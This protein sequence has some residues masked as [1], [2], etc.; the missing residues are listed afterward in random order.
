MQLKKA[1]VGHGKAKKEQVQEMVARLLG[2]PAKP[3][4]D[5]A[6]ALAAAIC[7]A[8][9]RAQLMLIAQNSNLSGLSTKGVRIKNGRLVSL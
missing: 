6:D 4:A 2:L 3:Q 8:Q 9:N 7:H 1:V 5:A